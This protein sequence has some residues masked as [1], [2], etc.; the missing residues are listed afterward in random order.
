M[1]KLTNDGE[2]DDHEVE[3]VPANGEKVVPQGHD[4]D[5]TLSGEDD[6]EGQVDVVQDVLHLRGL[7][8]RLHHHRDH[9]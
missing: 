9:I 8:V 5:E 6:N 3:D 1:S 4:L 7:L 2:D